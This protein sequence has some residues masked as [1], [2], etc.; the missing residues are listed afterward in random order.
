MGTVIILKNDNFQEDTFKV[1]QSM[2]ILRTCDT[3]GQ[4]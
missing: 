2:N 4:P 1:P 3:N